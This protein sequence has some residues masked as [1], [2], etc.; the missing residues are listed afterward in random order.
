MLVR[1]SLPLRGRLTEW[2]PLLISRDA[3]SSTLTPNTRDLGRRGLRL[4]AGG[5]GFIEGGVLGSDTLH[6]EDPG[7]DEY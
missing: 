1:G 4:G 2:R 6:K 3:Q 5:F 7:T